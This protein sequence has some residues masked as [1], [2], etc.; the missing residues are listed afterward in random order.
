LGC[1]TCKCTCECVPC[2]TEI[3]T[4]EKKH[5][6]VEFVRLEAV[7]GFAPKKEGWYAVWDVKEGSREKMVWVLGVYKS[8]KGLLVYDPENRNNTIRPISDYAWLARVVFSGEE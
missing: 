4:K 5:K 7:D 2:K 3:K 1:D 6:D 8:K